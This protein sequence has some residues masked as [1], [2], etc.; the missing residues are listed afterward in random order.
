VG[1]ARAAGAMGIPIGVSTMSSRP[2][3][4]VV[5][6]T[7]TPVWYQLYLSGGRAVAEKAIARAQA[8][9]CTALLLTVDMLRTGGGSSNSEARAQIPAKVTVRNALHYLPELIARPQWSLD[10]ARD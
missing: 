3:E 1:A 7:P 2:I 9:G 6:A 5:A 8:A 10:F 4:D